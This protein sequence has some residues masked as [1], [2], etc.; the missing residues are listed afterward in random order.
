MKKITVLVVAFCL[1]FVGFS[2][3]VL[4]KPVPL[5]VQESAQLSALAGNDGLLNL[6]AGGSFPNAPRPMDMREESALR[7]LSARSGNLEKLK[8]G[9]YLE[10]GLG[11]AVLIITLIILLAR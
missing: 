4:A 3:K 2:G 1:V 11:T 9:E 10:I 7:Q 8:A 5:S 6:K